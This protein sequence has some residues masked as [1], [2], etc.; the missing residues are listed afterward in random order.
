[1]ALSLSEKGEEPPSCSVIGHSVELDAVILSKE[2]AKVHIGVV[3]KM[4]TKLIS[5][6]KGNEGRTDLEV[7]GLHHRANNG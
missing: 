5:L 3:R 1:L 4:P 2:F 6:H 7:V